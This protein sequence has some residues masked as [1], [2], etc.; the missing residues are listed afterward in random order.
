[1]GPDAWMLIVFVTLAVACAVVA[2][3]RYVIR[4]RGQRTHRGIVI[5]EYEPPAD[6]TPLEASIVLQTERKGVPA[7]TLH[8]AVRGALRLGQEDTE[9][10]G[11]RA[12]VAALVD[13]ARADG[14]Q[15]GALLD[16]LFGR[17]AKPG[18]EFHFAH[19]GRGTAA[20]LEMMWRFARL[21][22]D[23]LRVPES[24]AMQ[25]VILIGAIIL[26][27]PILI[28]A[29]DAVE[30]LGFTAILI[31][32]VGIAAA[33][34]AAVLV[35]RVPLSAAGAE[36]RRRLEG[37]RTFIGWAE[38]DRIRMLQSP[39]GAER[40]RVDVSDLR[41]MLHLYEPLLPYAV[42]FG[43]ER[44]WVRQLGTLYAGAGEGPDWYVSG[45]GGDAWIAVGAADGIGDGGMDGFSETSFSDAM[46]DFSTGAGSSDSGWGDF[47]GFSDG[48]GGDSGAG[49]DGGGGGGGD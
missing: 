3:I 24:Q 19:A 20:R 25:Y 9:T 43:M 38:A 31:G 8:H 5:A 29:G 14:A 21:R 39:D 49:G 26:A 32:A 22:T 17:D 44:E 16:G 37:L 30:E 48:G 18:A 45:Y 46:S 4:A 6:H 41:A 13:P 35:R 42:L 36:L 15:G 40:R 11:K 10:Q 34:T 12:F 1:M 7:F 47:G 33:V 2:A 27:I 28:S 23:A